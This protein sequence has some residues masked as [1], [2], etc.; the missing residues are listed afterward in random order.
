MGR[1]GPEAQDEAQGSEDRK[2]RLGLEV[3]VVDLGDDEQRQRRRKGLEPGG[4]PGAH[5]RIRSGGCQRDPSSEDASG[6]MPISR[7]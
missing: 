1:E 3:G 5:R 6:Q 2:L 4:P 7:K